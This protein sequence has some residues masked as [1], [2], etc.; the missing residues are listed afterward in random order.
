MF[1]LAIF[2]APL[3]MSQGYIGL[4]LCY[5]LCIGLVLL[6]WSPLWPFK[7]Q[8]RN[9][10]EIATIL[11]E[12]QPPQTQGPAT[13]VFLTIDE[14][15][16]SASLDE[17]S[18]SL[19]SASDDDLDAPERFV[20]DSAAANSIRTLSV[21]SPWL[22][23][24]LKEIGSMFAVTVIADPCDDLANAFDAMDLHDDFDDLANQ[25]AAVNFFPA[26]P[27]SI[28]KTA[29]ASAAAA[30]RKGVRF[31]LPDFVEEP[32]SGLPRMGNVW[33]F[34]SH[35]P[36]PHRCFEKK[37]ACKNHRYQFGGRPDRVDIEEVIREEQKE[38]EERARWDAM[39]V[40]DE[41]MVSRALETED[42]IT[43]QWAPR[44][45]RSLGINSKNITVKALDFGVG[46]MKRMAPV[47]T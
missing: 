17:S 6:S 43:L 23:Q 11:A 3:L 5:F 34:A 7:I 28:L 20:F 32:D 16:D 33:G 19:S 38:Q 44:K 27:K 22:D 31:D 10:N 42:P 21:N 41:E 35:F 29:S 47:F 13:Q 12:W 40:E 9:S 1:T 37:G 36:L 25:L 18:D 30:P 14:L 39:E 24:Q 8:G 4:G 15:E 46:E 45:P 2:A 26:P